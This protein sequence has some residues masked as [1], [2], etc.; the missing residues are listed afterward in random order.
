[1]KRKRLSDGT[2][3]GN[4]QP[5]KLSSR[6]R[7]AR[8]LEAEVLALKRLGLPTFH[9]IALQI[10]KVGRGLAQP[11]VEFPPGI[12]FPHDYSIS[13]VACWRACQRA[14][15]RGPRLRAKEMRDLDTD[16]LEQGILAT[17]KGVKQG[18]PAALRNL[19][20][21][22]TAKARINGYM[23]PRTLELTGKAGGP[24]EVKRADDGD[25]E[26]MLQRLS[27]AEQI[28]FMRLHNK[29]RGLWIEPTETKVEGR[30][31]DEETN[32]SR[33][34]DDGSSDPTTR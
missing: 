25:A 20:Q 10:T 34:E 21:L 17:Q 31:M 16:R 19:A 1:M 30:K 29:A 13:D 7:H 8:W 22:I 5:T 3:R 33:G 23:E 2:F 14:L 15:A 27:R 26:Q 9:A 12:T 28:E 6:T 4:H 24:V 11:M 32:D 18:D